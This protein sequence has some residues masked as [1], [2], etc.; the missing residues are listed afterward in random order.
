MKKKILNVFKFIFGISIL[1]LLFTKANMK[2]F[3]N[4]ILKADYKYFLLSILLYIIGQIISSKKWML[5]S[6]KLGFENKFFKFIKLYFLGMFYN[7]FLPTNIGGD[8]VKALKIRDNTSHSTKRALT[9]VLA[10]RLTGLSVLVFFI[11]LGYILSPI[12]NTIINLI[13][14]CV[15]FGTIFGGLITFC[16]IKYPK[17]ISSKYRKYSEILLTPIC[18]KTCILKIFIFSIIFHLIIILIH[19]SIGKMFDIQIPVS[20]Y[21]LLYPISAIAS[22]L[23]ISISGIG[24]KEFV[25]VYLLKLINIDTS[26]ALIFSLTFTMVILFSSFFGIIPFITSDKPESDKLNY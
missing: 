8:V 24:I 10:D 25:Y 1:Y 16:V 3:L 23:P 5:I 15:I 13:T 21:L 20:Y 18:D 11:I 26:S 12:K 9:S 6:E 7:T 17:L 14:L 4:L 22:A 2:E 19:I